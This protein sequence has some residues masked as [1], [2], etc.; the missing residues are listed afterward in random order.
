M[1]QSTAE[2]SKTDVEDTAENT[3]IRVLHVDDDAGF[4]KTAG[5]ILEMQGA[6]QVDTTSSPEEA[7]EILKKE[8]YDVVVSDYRMLGKDG[9]Q[10]LK[11]LR[12]NGNGIP[13]IMF[14]GKG[15]EE[16]AIKALNLGADQYIDKTGDPETVYCE[17]AHGIRQAV[18]RNKAEEALRE[19]EK[20][21]KGI[22]ESAGD[23]LIY[24]D[25]FGRILDANRKALEIFG[26]AKEEVLGKHFTKI[27]ILSLK[28]IP[29]LMRNF[30]SVM[31]GKKAVIDYAITNKN[32]KVIPLECS[33]SILKS[34]NESMIAVVVRDSSERKKTL[35]KLQIL[36]DKLGVVG[37]LTRHDV[38]NKLF[39][40]TNNIYLAK[41]LLPD[42]HRALA[43][44]REIESACGQTTRILDFAATYESMGV[45]QLALVD[46]GKAVEEAASLFS[47][48]QDV[49]V[50]NECHGLGVMADS[51]LRQ[52][53]YNLFD[54]SL[55]HGEKVSRI[56]VHY[57]E[58]KDGLK[59]LYEDDGVGIPKAIKPKI[60]AEGF[61]TDKG[62]G[63]G[64][65]LVKRMLEVYGWTI[66]EEGKPGKGVKFVMTIPKTNPNGKENYQLS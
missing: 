30:A 58:G 37:G 23:G 34:N 8:S 45:E 64:L 32:G 59:L 66:E 63:Y 48:L 19:S 44:L 1:T 53:F 61:T 11:E 47:D 41:Q 52:L 26:G 15:R 46:M 14:T 55:K 18:Q 21:F 35:E 4:L 54:N 17:L 27:G 20:K 33:A 40:V 36:N 16:V 9:L 31:E 65:H 43:Y 7:L 39:T 28:D 51:L 10:F 6:F 12:A 22:F 60:F 2:F 24:L 49:K 62:F 50:V 56:S 25:A 3:P 42:D 57:E 38:R 29:T 5:A 13:F